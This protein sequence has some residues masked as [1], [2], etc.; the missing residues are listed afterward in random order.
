MS[1]IA[2]SH[3]LLEISIGY[4]KKMVLCSGGV[5]TRNKELIKF[6]RYSDSKIILLEVVEQ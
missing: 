4:N 6:V 5:Q 1:F 3:L 2:E